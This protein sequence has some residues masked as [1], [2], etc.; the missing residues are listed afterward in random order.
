MTRIA[1]SV[2]L[3]IAIG[4]G[5]LL[6]ALWT[7]VF[8]GWWPGARADAV[9]IG[10]VSSFAVAAAAAIWAFSPLSLRR[11]LLGFAAVA[12]LLLVLALTGR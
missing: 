5:Y 1:L 7:L 9:L 3:L 4:G 6:A 11:M 10:T 2:R 12:V 8:A